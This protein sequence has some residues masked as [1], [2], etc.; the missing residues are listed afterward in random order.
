VISIGTVQAAG[1]CSESSTEP[2]STG[3]VDISA[4][5]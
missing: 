4:P 5:V 3:Q 1:A 2:S